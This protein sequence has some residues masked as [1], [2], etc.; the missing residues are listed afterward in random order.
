ME[1]NNKM[2]VADLETSS[3]KAAEVDSLA[4]LAEQGGAAAQLKLG[5]LYLTGYGV[6]KDCKCGARWIEM[7]AKQG[8]PEAQA[9]LGFTY[10]SGKGR[11]H[12]A[13]TARH[14]FMRAAN[15]GSAKAELA[16]ACMYYSAEKATD[17][18][19]ILRARSAH[20][21]CSVVGAE[22]D[23]KEGDRWLKKAAGHGLAEAQF[24]LGGI[25]LFGEGVKLNFAEAKRW[26]EQAAEQGHPKASL[27]LSKMYQR[28]N[29]TEADAKKARHWLQRAADHGDAEAKDIL[30]RRAR[31]V[32]ARRLR[33]IGDKYAFGIRRQQD[34]AE[35][36]CWYTRAAE[37]GDGDAQY[38]LAFLYAEG[39]GVPKNVEKFRQLIQELKERG[40]LAGFER[41][42][43]EKKLKYCGADPP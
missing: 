18:G 39:S 27:T 8:L 1:S 41:R 11:R 5:K 35:A 29:G 20:M 28:G 30:Q 24:L 37:T 16:L 2:P 34:L 19:D 10:L 31:A 6:R 38:I 43:H 13:A 22:N 17:E 33:R 42:L 25:Y 21:S 36:A 9:I 32:E 12:N 40:S 3:D 4:R 23:T 26:V 7:A 15:Q 14:W